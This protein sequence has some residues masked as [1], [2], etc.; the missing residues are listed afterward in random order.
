MHT[1]EKLLVSKFSQKGD[2]KNNLQ[3]HKA[4]KPH[5]CEVCSKAFSKRYDL[6]RHL[7][8][9]TGEKPYFCEVCNKP[10]S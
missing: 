2:L 3:T 1:G 8:T 10:F 6:M 9:H 7:R 5:V 4:E